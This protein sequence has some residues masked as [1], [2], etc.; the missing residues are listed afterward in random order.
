MS[1]SVAI[2]VQN[3]YVERLTAPVA[4]FA[5]AAGI[6]L[7][8]RSSTTNFDPD[9]CGID[10]TGFRFVLTYGSVQFLR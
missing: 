2:F 1:E 9:D 8:D 10:W 4:I 7:Y 5:R 3:N 6:T